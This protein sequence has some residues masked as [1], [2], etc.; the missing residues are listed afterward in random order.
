MWHNEDSICRECFFQWYDPD[1]GTFDN[2]NPVELGNYVRAKH[3]LPP[4]TLPIG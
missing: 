1:N 4:L 2:C 3:G